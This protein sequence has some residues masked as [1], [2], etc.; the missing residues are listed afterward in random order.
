MILRHQLNVLQR[1]SSK[2]PRFGMLDRLVFAGLYRLAPNVLGALAKPETVIKWHR[3]GFRSYWRWKSRRRGGRPTVAPEIRKLI[4]E[5]SIA[6]PL[7]ERRGSMENSSRSASISDRPAWPSTWPSERPAIPR[8]EDVPSQSC[9]RH[10]RD[11]S[12][13]RTDNLISSA[14]RLVDCGAWS[15]YMVEPNDPALDGLLKAT[16]R[17][18]LDLLSQRV[19]HCIIC[20]SWIVDRQSVGLLLLATPAVIK[21]TSASACAICRECADLPLETLG[22]A[23]TTALQAAA[24]GGRFEPME[25]RR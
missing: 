3:A 25:M 24:P 12:V 16:A 19:R 7:W 17:R 22:R 1:K 11:G 18:W 15:T 10:R 8:L 2:R 5:M 9:R 4:R 13:R 20:S 14:L 23:A 6:N 21:P